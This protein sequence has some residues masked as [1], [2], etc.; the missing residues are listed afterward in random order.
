MALVSFS[1]LLPTAASCRRCRRTQN[2][3]S[4][5]VEQLEETP[6]PR[7]STTVF[8]DRSNLYHPPGTSLNP[9]FWSPI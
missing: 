2:P 6:L 7:A 3:F 5:F 8:I 9:N 1:K 4:H